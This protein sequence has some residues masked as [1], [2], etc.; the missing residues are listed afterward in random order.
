MKNNIVVL[1]AIALGAFSATAQDVAPASSL[2]VTSSF[3]FESEYVFRGAQFADA[4]ITPAIDIAYGNA[5]AGMWFAIPVENADV[6]DCNEMDI[7]G[8]YSTSL[9]SLLTIDFGACRYTYGDTF[10]NFMDKSN[11]L[12][13]YVGL[14]ADVILSPSVYVYRDFDLLTT[15]IEGSIGHSISL[16]DKMSVDLG[17][18]IGYVSSEYDDNDYTYYG[19]TADMSYSIND[20]SSIGFGLRYSGSDND[21]IYTGDYGDADMKASDFWYGLSFSSGF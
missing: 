8:G 12:E 20:S 17:A 2:S 6:V 15:T 4:I 11:S 18:S 13:A 1:A 21:M 7:Y 9:S 16:S 3:G 10:T 14:S 5:Y 19:A